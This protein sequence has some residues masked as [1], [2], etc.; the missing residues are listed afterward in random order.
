MKKNFYLYVEFR[1]K[2]LCH[3]R[4]E[5]EVMRDFL[6]V[7]EQ[8]I[9]ATMDMRFD[10]FVLLVQEQNIYVTMDMRGKANSS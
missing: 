10:G 5:S 1:D 7:Q 8:S 2:N 9:Y 3:N 4:H 6:M